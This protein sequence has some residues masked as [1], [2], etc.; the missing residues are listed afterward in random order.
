MSTLQT[1]LKTHSVARINNLIESAIL[2]KNDFTVTGV[3]TVTLI[4]NKCLK[5]RVQLENSLTVASI[6]EAAADAV[7]KYIIENSI[8]NEGLATVITEAEQ[9]NA[10]LNFNI[11]GMVM[12][13][14][15]AVGMYVLRTSSG[16]F[17]KLLPWL[18]ILAG[19]AFIVIG[20]IGDDV[21]ILQLIIGGVMILLG[22]GYLLF[23][24]NSNYSD[25]G[26][27]EG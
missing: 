22:G 14:L 27:I 2:N 3:T 17:I 18:V 15:A 12:V 1:A 24:H 20:I 19:L 13:A 10:G 4:V 16:L 7:T 8:K 21:D 6:S 25:H 11:A 26:Q 23:H 9:T 5:S